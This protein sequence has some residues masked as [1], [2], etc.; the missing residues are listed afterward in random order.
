MADGQEERVFEFLTRRED[1]AQLLDFVRHVSEGFSSAFADSARAVPGE[2]SD[3]SAICARGTLRRHFLDKAIRKAA[4]DSGY[5]LNMG[6][7]HGPH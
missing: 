1:P 2:P 7:K 6:R 4:A 5:A 3:R